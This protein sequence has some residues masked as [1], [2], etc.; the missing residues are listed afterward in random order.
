M[1]HSDIAE[2]AVIPVPDKLKGHVPF[3]LLVLK[4][5]KSET[6]TQTV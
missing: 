1:E 3:G 2:V 5:S 6:D 4:N